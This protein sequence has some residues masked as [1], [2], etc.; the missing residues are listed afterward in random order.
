[1]RVNAVIKRSQGAQNEENVKK[2]VFTYEGLSVDFSARIVTIDGKRIEMTPKEYELF[3]YMVKNK[4]LALTREKL[5]S[6]VWGYDFFG[7]ERTLDTHIKLLRKSLGEYSRCIVRFEGWVTVLKQSNKRFDRHYLPL[8]F[9][10]LCY[11]LLF[12]FAI[13]IVL[14]VFQTFFLESFYTATKS[15]R[16]KRTHRLFQ[17]RLKKTKTLSEQLKICKLQFTFGICL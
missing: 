12:G 3:F 15:S 6:E 17:S 7:D 4:G 13:V 1:M 16:L 2:D 8:N 9:K 10:L 11:F 14:W 5:I